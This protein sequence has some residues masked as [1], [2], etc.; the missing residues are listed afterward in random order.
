MH[1]M[2]GTEC[3]EGFIEI[4]A[5]AEDI[6]IFKKSPEKVEY[7]L[8]ADPNEIE[9]KKRQEEEQIDAEYCEEEIRI[10]SENTAKDQH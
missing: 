6:N 9:K 8:E 1:D 2:D 5:N 4:P 10:P 3:S 7:V